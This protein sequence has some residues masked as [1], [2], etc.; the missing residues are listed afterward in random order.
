MNKFFYVAALALGVSSV[1]GAASSKTSVGSRTPVTNPTRTECVSQTIRGFFI[2]VGPSDD[3]DRETYS[4]VY[5][6]D[7]GN[8]ITHTEGPELYMCKPPSFVRGLEQIRDGDNSGNG[9]CVRSW[10][11]CTTK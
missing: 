2:P 11:C 1:E 8:T 5:A 6:I 4:C 9:D 3:P 7:L 10:E